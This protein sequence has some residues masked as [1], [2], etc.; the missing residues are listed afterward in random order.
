MSMQLDPWWGCEGSNRISNEAVR[1][2]EARLHLLRFAFPAK[3]SY[4]WYSWTR[5]QKIPAWACLGERAMCNIH[6]LAMG[7]PPQHILYQNE[8]RPFLLPQQSL[9][10]GKRA[11]L[12][13]CIYVERER[14]IY[15]SIHVPGR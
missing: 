6:E 9:K 11:R 10:A 7:H 14:Y 12:I 4:S 13:Y 15:R 3:N 2:P 8:A 1:S 5:P